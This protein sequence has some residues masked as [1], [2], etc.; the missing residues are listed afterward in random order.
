MFSKIVARSAPFR[1]LGAQNVQ[2]RFLNLHEYQSMEVMSKF[3][4]A[5]PR[6]V[7]A[8]TP[9]EAKDKAKDFTPDVVIKSQVLAGGRGLGYFKENKFQGGV[10]VIPSEKTEEY[11]EKMIGKTLIT[12][13]TG[14]AGKPN[15]S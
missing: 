9:S 13:Q 12:K 4:V 6:G 8:F 7:V 11:A 3:G 2:K 1:T 10:H 5:V 14:E 15:N